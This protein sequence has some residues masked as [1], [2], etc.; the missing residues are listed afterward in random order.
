MWEVPLHVFPV[1]TGRP[2]ASPQNGGGNGGGGAGGKAAKGAGGGNGGWT[3][4]GGGNGDGA[5]SGGDKG[6]GKGKGAS[7]VVI[8]KTLCDSTV[9]C[10]NFQRGTCSNANCNCTLPVWGPQGQWAC[11][12]RA[13][14][15]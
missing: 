13:P 4:G 6:G 11:V 3:S 7:R 10:N 9:L 12:W 15:G 1:G 14:S 5:G 8:A 2:I